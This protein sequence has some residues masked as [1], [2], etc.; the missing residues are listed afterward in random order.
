M[1]FLVTMQEPCQA[2]HRSIVHAKTTF[3]AI[4]KLFG[5]D[6][7]PNTYLSVKPASEDDARQ[8]PELKGC[9]D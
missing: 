5:A 6:L 8:Y 3:D 1:K 4:N 9:H 7:D 2:R